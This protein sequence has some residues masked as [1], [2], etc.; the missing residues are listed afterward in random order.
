[1]R[2]YNSLSRAI[3]QFRPRPGRPI[4][5]YVCGI[6]P[7]DTTHLGHAFT[8]AMFDVL[9][10]H[11]ETVH[12]WPVRYVQNVTDVDDDILRRSAETSQDWQALG[13]Q[14]T[15]RF[16]ADM[17][18][19]RLRPPDAF[20]AATAH[21]PQIRLLIERML[22]GGAAYERSGSV[23]FRSGAAKD[24]GLLT[25]EPDLLAVA[26]ERGSTLAFEAVPTQLRAI[27][28]ISDLEELIAGQPGG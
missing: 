22:E 26:N 19:L 16:A 20:P 15:R 27:A 11:L 23:Y 17:T 1:M 6:T 4:Q 3:E 12:G 21:M 7:Y 2:L 24:M 14:W 9:I 28:R 13:N 10:R 8:Y 5:V 25:D 18:A